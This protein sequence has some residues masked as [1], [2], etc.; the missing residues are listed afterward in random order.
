MGPNRSDTGLRRRLRPL[1]ETTATVRRKFECEV[2]AGFDCV[3]RAHEQGLS[4]LTGFLSARGRTVT[5]R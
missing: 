5:E 1:S 4:V 2:G 3:C